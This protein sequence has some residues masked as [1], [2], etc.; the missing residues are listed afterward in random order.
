[1]EHV[2]RSAACSVQ[3]IVLLSSQSCSYSKAPEARTQ[4]LHD[5]VIFTY[6][7]VLPAQLS[8]SLPHESDYVV[9]YSLNYVHVLLI[10]YI[11]WY[12][13]MYV[14]VV[15]A[16]QLLNPVY[17]LLQAGVVRLRCSSRDPLVFTGCLD[18]GVRLWDV[19]GGECVREWWGHTKDILD[20]TI[21]RY[22]PTSQQLQIHFLQVAIGRQ[23]QFKLQ[24]IPCRPI[25]LHT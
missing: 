4:V 21:A 1:M 18:G 11:V 23:T 24:G 25:F 14:H 16:A 5:Y 20:L 7:W 10:M 19:R 15:F 2:Y 8:S 13:L 6:T 12:S 22:Y 9:W 3:T 17:D